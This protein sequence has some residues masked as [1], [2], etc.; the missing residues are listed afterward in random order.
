MPTTASILFFE[1]LIYLVQDGSPASSANISQR[2]AGEKGS[3]G[4][5]NQAA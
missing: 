5:G 3:K 4:E 2:P 1:A